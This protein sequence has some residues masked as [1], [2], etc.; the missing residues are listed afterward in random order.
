MM[1]EEWMRKDFETGADRA[2][3]GVVGAVDEARDPCLDNC[4]GTHAAGLDGDIQRG[5]TKAVVAEKA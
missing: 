5:I 3:L 2:A 4:T 1:V